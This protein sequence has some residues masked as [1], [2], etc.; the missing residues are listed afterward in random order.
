LEEGRDVLT[1]PGEITSALSRG[2]NALLRL[3]AVAVTGSDDVLEAIGF[4][5][6][7][8]AER[9]V[10]SA[11]ASSVLAALDQGATTADEIAR[12]TTLDPAGV[13]VALTELELT[14]LVEARSGIYRR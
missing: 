3:G 4:D 9:A 11:G 14:G 5:P 8:P 13:A 7:A 10:M 2:T 6:P 1:V 12:A